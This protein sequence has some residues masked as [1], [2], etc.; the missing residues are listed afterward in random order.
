MIFKTI[1]VFTTNFRSQNYDYFCQEIFFCI[2]KLQLSK[3][4]DITSPIDNKRENIN[5]FRALS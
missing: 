4:Q 2:I 1:H 5:E 3:N